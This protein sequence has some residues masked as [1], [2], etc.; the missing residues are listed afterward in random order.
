MKPDASDSLSKAREQDLP[1]HLV[2]LVDAHGIIQ[3]VNGEWNP[4]QTPEDRDLPMPENG[5]DCF[6]FFAGKCGALLEGSD[7]WASA[8]RKVLDR[9]SGGIRIESC[10]PVSTGSLWIETSIVPLSVHDIEGA[11]ITCIDITT[12]KQAEQKLRKSEEQLRAIIDYEPECVKVVDLEGRLREMN[13]A[14]LKIIEAGSLAQ[15]EGRH[16]AD[17]VHPDDREAFLLLHQQVCAGEAGQQTFRVI[18]TKGRLIWVETHS[19][20]LHD[21]NGKVIS[22]LSVTQDISERKKV[23]EQL[24]QSEATMSAAQRISRF[25]SWEFELSDLEDLNNNTL[26]WSDEIFRIFGHEVGGIEA[27]NDNFFRA[28]HPDDREMIQ[29]AVSEA[30]RTQGRYSIDHRIILPNGEVR[31]IHEDAQLFRDESTGRPLKMVGTAHDITDRK[32]AEE[33]LKTSEARFRRA[34]ANASVGFAITDM[35][36]GILHI[37]KQYCRITGY[38][39]DEMIG[40]SFVSITHPDDVARKQEL[41]QQLIAGEINDFIVEKRYL[42]KNGDVAWVENSVSII[43]DDSGAALNMVVLCKDITEARRNQEQLRLLETCVAHLNDVVLITEAEPLREPGPRIVFVNDAFTA[44]TG[45]TRQET[46]GRSPRFLQGPDS[47]CAA[48][49]RIRVALA[50]GRPVKEEL[51]NHKKDGSSFCVEID[52]VPITAPGGKPHH[53]V[54]IQRDI[55]ARKEAETRLWKSN[56]RYEKQRAALARLMR[57]GVMQAVDLDEAFRL[58]T[59]EIANAMEVARV[60]IWRFD[61]NR[62]AIV[63]QELYET[64]FGRHSSGLEL[65]GGD[66]PAYFSALK[67]NEVIS[68]DDA[69]CDPRTSEF[70]D[71]YLAPLG[72]TSMLDTPLHVGG[73]LAGVLCHEHVGPLRSWAPEEQSFAVSLANFI[74]LVLAQWERRQIEEMLRQ[75]ASLLDKAND[76]ILVRDL[77]HNITY[78]NKSAENLYGWTAEEAVGHKVSELLYNDDAQFREITARVLAN[79]EWTGEI[80]QMTK[81]GEQ[82]IVEGRWTLVRD[83]AGRPKCILAINTNITEKKRLEDQI[84]RSQ[85]MESIGTLAGGIAHD[86]NNV[87]T[88]IMMSVDLLKLRISDPACRETLGTIASSASRGAEMLNQVLSFARGVEGQKMPVQISRLMQDLARIVRDTFPKNIHLRM[89]ELPESW[90]VSGDPT[91]IHQVLLNLCVNARDAMPAGGTLTISV[92]N[93]MIDT[94][95]AAMNIEAREGPHILISV[96]DDGVGITREVLHKIFD[97][98][99]TTKGPGKG[100]GLG[101]STSLAIVKSH[102]GFIRVYSEPGHGSRFNVYLPAQPVSVVELPVVEERP[103]PRGNHDLILLVDDEASVREITRQTLEAYNYRV[104]L[105]ADG[106]EAVTLYSKHQNEIAAVLTDMMMPVMDGSTTIQV[107]MKMNPQVRIIAASGITSNGSIAKAAGAGVKHFLPKPYTAETILRSLQHVLGEK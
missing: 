30:I 23:E 90:T 36:G 58:I 62:S 17:L 79:G 4:F 104:L 85:R 99:F 76:A 93:L 1:R 71:N 48:L 67:Q 11:L 54:A 50:K 20:P 105:A 75:Q 34:F 40:K 39:E 24:R 28:V 35:N 27:T 74:S 21:S 43:R 82:L 49:D 106:A 29:Q 88:P 68:A 78:W 7:R 15:V 53:F 9:Q 63:C 59:E 96:E 18:S 6:V 8:L 32:L 13:P 66:Y 70:T 44:H 102:G 97:P 26:H 98:F 47:D 107:L 41:N 73:V 89:Q 12:R 80:Q 86:L 14:G 19:V 55:T 100:T 46:I 69:R 103:L 61:Q 101:L 72:I 81:A 57:G 92:D 91:Q 22:V 56:L 31:H 38:E 65:R 25:G 2:I 51:I 95:Y 84:L 5:G 42:C 3:A 37:N 60:S 87:L 45:Y 64:S 52:I 77:D 94:Q 10:L 33:A 16:V 83:A